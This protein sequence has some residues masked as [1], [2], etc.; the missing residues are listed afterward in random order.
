M[1][2]AQSYSTAPSRKA[3]LGPRGYNPVRM[4]LD[5]RFAVV[6]TLLV[7]PMLAAS[8]FAAL[9]VRRGDL[10]ADLG[11][12][13]REIAEALS[14]G[15]EPLDPE[16]MEETLVARQRAARANNDPF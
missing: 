13:A 9:K 10:E 1:P 16:I 3:P 5:A 7:A 2:M 8:E 15:I 11:R 14:A 12:E 4:R 6:T